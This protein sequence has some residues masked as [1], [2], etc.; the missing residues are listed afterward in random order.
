MRVI[1]G[2][3]CIFIL[4]LLTGCVE[5]YYPETDDLFTGTLV[6]NATLTNLPGIQ[7]F[8]I[9]R[10]DGLI[11][12][13]FI[14][15]SGC[16]VE[17]ENQEGD[18]LLFTESEPGYYSCD[19]PE[20]FMHFGDQ[21]MLRV[22]T[23]GGKTYQSD[24]SSLNP[25]TDIDKIYYEMESHPTSDPDVFIDGIRFYIDFQVDADSSEF[26][27]WELMETY[28]FHNPDY[29]GFI[30]SYDRILRPFPDSLADR[31]CWITGHVNDLYTLDVANLTGNSYAHMPLHYV[32]NETQRLSYGY[33]LLVRQHAMDAPAFRYWDELRK[34]S[35]GQS[36]IY[37]R[38]PSITPSNIYSVDE[39][40]ER[41]LG[42]FGVSGVAEKRLF[43]K[44]VEGLRKYDVMHCFPQSEPPRF[45]F[46]MTTDLPVYLS[47]A[48]DPLTG[49]QVFGETG[50]E[51]LD[52]SVRK[53]SSGDPPYYWPIE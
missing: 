5:R 8:Q 36:G 25:P 9:S 49:A 22:V 39:P 23:S 53:G 50:L 6:I 12:P 14:P 7:T 18:Q 2:K 27:R 28:E 41:I 52:C 35:Q 4:L 21:Y 31:Q 38:L 51:C 42:F 26:M 44:E 16:M 46:L 13:E 30:Y 45:R 40:D 3:G 11:Y 19:V 33:S 17:V 32:S 29:D 15:E 34:N 1:R 24:Y 20:K 47:R 43:V 10:S 37:D 48:E